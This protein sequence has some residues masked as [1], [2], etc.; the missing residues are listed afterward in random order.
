VT[1]A[2]SRST[3][4]VQKGRQEDNGESDRK[5]VQE[6]MQFI[7]D[8]ITKLNF[9]DAKPPK[10][11]FH[12]EQE[13]SE[14]VVKNLDTITKFVPVV[15]SEVYE[16]LQLRQPKEGDEVVF[17]GQ[18]PESSSLDNEF[19]SNTEIDNLAQQ[20]EA[21]SKPTIN[22]ML[23]SIKKFAG[24]ANSLDDLEDGLIDVLDDVDKSE[25]VS[26]LEDTR[27][28]SNALGLDDA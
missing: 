2:G 13:V 28:I 20:G 15:K 26:A 12:D 5:M 7:P 22:R 18:K 24:T 4:D 3:A 21:K 9:P 14:S 10:W 16:L 8:S 1:E 17:Q 23:S 19:Q 6:A 25:L 11:K 27:V